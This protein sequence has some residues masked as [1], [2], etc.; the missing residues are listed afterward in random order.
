MN[1]ALILL[2]L[3]FL[4][5]V[6]LL[7]FL[8]LIVWLIYQDMRTTTAVLASQKQPQGFLR[9]IA[10]ESGT[11]AINTTYPLLPVTSI[12]RAISSTIVLDNHYVSSAH[13][14]ITRRHSQWWLEDLGSRNGT[15]LND[16]PL[17]EATVVSPGDVITI[18]DTKLKIEF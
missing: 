1:M 9:L 16:L 8:L 17:S 7:G 12:G 13:A 3:R 15:L 14:L 2:L 6:L 4:S 18:G 5:A 11:Q 10:N